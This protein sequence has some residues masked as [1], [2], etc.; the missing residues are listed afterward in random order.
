MSRDSIKLHPKYALNSTIPVCFYCGEEK[1][2]IAF[3]GANYEEEAPMHMCIDILPC[4]ACKTKYENYVLVVEATEGES[5]IKG[6]M[7]FTGRWAAVRQGLLDIPHK[8][9][10]I[11][12]ELMWELINL[13]NE[14]KEQDES[15]CS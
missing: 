2:E 6:K 14:R 15:S 5:G 7:N 10:F 4:E 3:L 9:A 13:E 11:S 8:V 1:N 12:P